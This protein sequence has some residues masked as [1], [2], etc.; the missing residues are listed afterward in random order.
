MLCE[1]VPSFFP[2][3][4]WSTQ[5]KPQHLLQVLNRR[6]PLNY[7]KCVVTDRWYE[8]PM[9]FD[10]LARTFRAAVHHS[11]PLNVKRNILT[12]MFISHAL[13]SA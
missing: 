2:C 7:V 3:P 6:E 9:S 5:L 4:F 13:L 1:N 12:S 11:S 10:G 8:P